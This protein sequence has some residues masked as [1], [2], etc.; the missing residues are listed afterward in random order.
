MY[1][2]L[3]MA[4]CHGMGFWDQYTEACSYSLSPVLWAWRQLGLVQP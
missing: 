3:G 2:C 4:P 1:L